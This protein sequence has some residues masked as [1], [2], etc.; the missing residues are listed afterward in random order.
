MPSRVLAG[1]P[2][3]AYT[4]SPNNCAP[5]NAIRIAQHATEV[6]RSDNTT[7]RAYSTGGTRHM[8]QITHFAP[9]RIL[10][11]SQEALLAGT[12]RSFSTARR[13]LRGL[14]PPPWYLRRH[15]C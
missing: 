9:E 4:S 5:P 11:R 10:F 14:S 3:L 2:V 8:C 7:T 15:G 12:Q 13:E 6:S 1:A